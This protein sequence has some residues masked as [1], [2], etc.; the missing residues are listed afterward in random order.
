MQKFHYF[1]NYIKWIISFWCN[2]IVY[3]MLKTDCTRYHSE[4]MLILI[5]AIHVYSLISK[6]NS[7][8]TRQIII[9]INLG[10]VES[11]RKHNC[12]PLQS[13][14]CKEFC[15]GYWQWCH[16][17]LIDAVKQYGYPSLFITISPS[18][19]TFP[20]VCLKI[21]WIYRLYFHFSSFLLSILSYC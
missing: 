6:S 5:V 4:T 13:L 11:G 2:V 15:T 18:E 21:W 3:T 9:S 20:K 19:W 12:T 16:L 8:N 14:D 10:A 7:K 17:F 1:S